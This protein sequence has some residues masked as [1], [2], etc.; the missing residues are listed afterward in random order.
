MKKVLKTLMISL[1]LVLSMT[2]AAFANPSKS[3]GDELVSELKA[4]GVPNSYIGNIVE[5][6]Q[7]TSISQS[8]YNK[9]MGYINEA[10]AIIGETKNLDKLSQSDKNSLQSLASKA[11]NTL[12]LKVT[13]GKNSKGETTVS[14]TDQ[15]GGIILKLATTEVVGLVENF[16][17]SVI[18]DV[19][20]LAVELSNDPNKGQ[21]KPVGGGLTSTATI[22]PKVMLLGASMIIGAGFI[23]FKSK[24]QF[25]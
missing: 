16:D 21:F 2:A 19:L 18:V 9:A 6:L 4:I 5:Y 12:G 23:A 13:F 14:V 7:K 3:I 8:D 20:E 15:K 22:Y 1:V 11:G 17:M 25:A 24:K 10:K